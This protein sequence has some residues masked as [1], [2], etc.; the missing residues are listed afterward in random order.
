MVF[1]LASISLKVAAQEESTTIEESAASTSTEQSPP[2]NSTP[3]VN[4]TETKTTSDKR[5]IKPPVALLELHKKDLNHYLQP[6]EVT[7][8]L[9][10]PN[11]FIT[12]IK[13][14]EVANNKGVAILLA[15]WQQTATTPKGINFLRNEMPKQGWTTISIQ[16][17]AKPEN[18][19]SNALD[20]ADRQKENAEIIKNYQ[21]ELSKILEAV[22]EKAHNYPG[23]FL[24]IAE[25]NHGALLTE[26]YQQGKNPQPNALIVLSSYMFDKEANTQYALSLAQT[27]FPVL[28]L[29]LMRDHPIAISNAKERLSATKK[30]MKAIYR[31]RQLTNRA[32][33]YYPEKE[34]LNA[35]KSWITSI[36]W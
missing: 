13:E 12:L 32:S 35:I 22:M 15:D 20:L 31:Q 25:G 1:I 18:Y 3:E 7:S 17:P 30:E 21:S 27:T 19:P 10:G 6:E 5:N 16:P 14:S 34:L 8:L 11:D 24:V 26:L 28:D 2:E 23:I 4:A 36:G 33:S 29:Y 9:A